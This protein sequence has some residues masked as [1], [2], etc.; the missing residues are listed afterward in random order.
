MSWWGRWQGRKERNHRKCSI[1]VYCQVIV[2]TTICH[3]HQANSRMN[4]PHSPEHREWSFCD[5]SRNS[6]YNSSSWQWLF[7]DRYWR[8]QLAG[9]SRTVSMRPVVPEAWK[10]YKLAH[11]PHGKRI[12]FLQLDQWY[13]HLNH[14]L[15]WLAKLGSTLHTGG[16]EDHRRLIYDNMLGRRY[17]T[18]RPQRMSPCQ[19]KSECR[20]DCQ[21]ETE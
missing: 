2:P 16:N 3:Q 13:G 11:A 18:S 4:Y 15:P 21:R 20:I 14:S 6:N 10:K 17:G 9:M 12:V 7:C 5:N 19:R 8:V 1:A